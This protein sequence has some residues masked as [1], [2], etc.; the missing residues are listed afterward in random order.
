MR[1]IEARI[2]P[3]SSYDLDHD[4]DQV[5]FV[6][7]WL[8]WFPCALSCASMQSAMLKA[9]KHINGKVPTSLLPEE[10]A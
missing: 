2:E 1:K 8:T 7:L 4:H 10:F 6:Y 5:N 3:W 9:Y